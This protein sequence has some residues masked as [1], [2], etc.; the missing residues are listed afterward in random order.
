MFSL[1]MET[2]TAD[3]TGWAGV[4]R[5]LTNENII[6]INRV[7]ELPIHTILFDLNEKIRFQQTKS[8]PETNG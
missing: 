7:M 5:A 2:K 6:D 1:L 4:F 3:S 8:K